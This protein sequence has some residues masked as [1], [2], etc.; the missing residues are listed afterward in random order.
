MLLAVVCAATAAALKN[1]LM[2][3]I[4]DQR[5]E[6]G[7]YG[8]QH[9][10]TPNYDRIAERSMVFDRAYVQVALCSPSR[11][12]LLT[13]R[14]ADTSRVWDIS[15]DQYWRKCGGNFTTLPQTFKQH[16][17]VTVGMGKVFHPGGPSGNQD[18]KYSWSEEALI[19]PRGK[20][21]PG[22][23][24]LYEG[25]TQATG[26]HNGTDETHPC[27]WKY[28][29]E[30]DTMVADGMLAQHAAK[31]LTNLSHRATPFFLAVGFHKPHVPWYAPA[32]YWDLYREDSIT[33]A[34]HT[35][36]PANVPEVAMQTV[37]QTWGGGEYSDI[38]TVVK[39]EH[40]FD[41][42]FPLGNSTLP[43]WKALQMRHA[44]WAA[45]SFTDANI[46]KVLDALDAS[47]AVNNTV[48]ALW[49]D[50]GYQL[51]D[52]NMWAKQSNFEQATRVPFMIH[53]P[54]KAPGRTS[55]LV[56][57]IDLFPTLVSIMGLSA[58]PECPSGLKDS[59]NTMYCTEGRSLEPLLDQPDA[60]WGHLAFSQFE[61]ENDSVMGY[62]VRTNTHRYTEWIQFNAS[63]G[64]GDWSKQ[65]AR[66]LY[67]H[68]AHPVQSG[69]PESWAMETRNVAEDPAN[70]E[71]VQEL[72]TKLKAGW[73]AN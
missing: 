18:S 37:I 51:G 57:V 14:R 42:S 2:I 23:G 29:T 26:P 30:D 59:R 45:T 60:A 8:A 33:L 46:G 19:G 17:F 53:V 67:S 50:H 15:K 49:G 66:E 21:A 54:G 11:T 73:R 39:N 5:P 35:L 52:N 48:I 27:F 43:A 41:K 9:M 47:P 71:L 32:K 1:V 55:A 20:D 61:R 31:T 63:T 56:E 25:W 34:P 64:M 24:G 3:A 22:K 28:D 70:A 16:G 13:S 10:H 58:V 69:T 12:S 65:V 72:S 6:M 68:S 4:D 38:S 7:C 40:P 62:T 36:A 44:Y